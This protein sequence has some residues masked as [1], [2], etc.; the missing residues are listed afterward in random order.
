[1][2]AEGE[3][4]HQGQTIQF[5]NINLASLDQPQ[6]GVNL[7][8]VT[9]GYCDGLNDNQAAGLKDAPWAGGLP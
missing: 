2:W 9:L 8:K 1:M 6:E 3:Y 4:P 5:F 7:S